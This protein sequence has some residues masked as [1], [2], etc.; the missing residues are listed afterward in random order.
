MNN[1]MAGFIASERLEPCAGKLACT[2]LRGADNSNVVGLLDF[3][4]IARQ[5]R[6]TLN[7]N[8]YYCDLIFYHTILKCYILIDVKSG[9]LTHGDLGQM[10]LY[11]NYYDQECLTK[12]DSPTIGLILCA[13]KDDAMVKYTLGEKQKRIFASRYQL[14]LPSEQELADEIRR[15][16]KVLRRKKLT[17]V[18]KKFSGS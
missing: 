4:F 10:Q 11:V 13:E 18:K 15:E 17:K 2:V 12:G 1:R 14:Y 6:L 8:H 7:R 5:Q 16:L 3:A 9:T